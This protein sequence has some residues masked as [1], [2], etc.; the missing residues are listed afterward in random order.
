[1]KLV[2]WLSPQRFAALQKKFYN[3]TQDYKHYNTEL[4]LKQVEAKKNMTFRR[5]VT[6]DQVQIITS[7]VKYEEIELIIC[8]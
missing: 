6:I 1:M 7:S 5:H 2:Y 4:I 8:F 3:E